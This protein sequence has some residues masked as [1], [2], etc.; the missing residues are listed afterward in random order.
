MDVEGDT[1]LE[2]LGLRA[3]LMHCRLAATAGVQHF[4]VR[5]GEHAATVPHPR[6]LTAML[7]ELGLKHALP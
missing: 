5:L 6:K 1:M 7:D 2:R 3:A 4:D